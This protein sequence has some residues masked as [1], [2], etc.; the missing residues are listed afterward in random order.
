M[1]YDQEFGRIYEKA[2]Y[3]KVEDNIVALERSLEGDMQDIGYGIARNAAA[4]GSLEDVERLEDR[5]RAVGKDLKSVS[6]GIS[7]YESTLRRTSGFAGYGTPQ[8]P[9]GSPGTT[10]KL[11]RY[12]PDR[13]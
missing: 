11:M 9:Q 6:A 5:V 4:Y 3:A 7:D 8:R 10:R 2:N 13:D 1:N 12:F